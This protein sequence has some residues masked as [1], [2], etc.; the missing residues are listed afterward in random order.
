LWNL[1]SEALTE[2]IPIGNICTD[3]ELHFVIPWGSRDYED[4]GDQSDKSD[5][6]PTASR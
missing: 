1:K 4:E 5:A 2:N 6:I 3:H